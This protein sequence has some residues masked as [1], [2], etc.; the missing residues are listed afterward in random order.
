MRF[1]NIRV[2]E[3]DAVPAGEAWLVRQA[4]SGEV[5]NELRD[6]ISVPCILT[7]D[8]ARLGRD[9]TLRQIAEA[10]EA[11]GRGWLPPQAGAAGGVKHA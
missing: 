11:S 7:R 2:Y 3:H 5:P 10:Y 8:A 1:I 9:L 4:D 6:R